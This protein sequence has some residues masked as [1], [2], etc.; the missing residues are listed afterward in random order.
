MSMCGSEERKIRLVFVRKPDL[1]VLGKVNE[2]G[3]DCS[4]ICKFYELC[5]QENV[6]GTLNSIPE[7]ISR[8]RGYYFGKRDEV[9]EHCDTH[10]VGIEVP[11]DLDRSLPGMIMKQVPSALYAVFVAVEGKGAPWG[12]AHE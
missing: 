4:R 1:N 12:E 10:M 3:T 7:L 5:S 2:I 6:W 9:P 8:T 11:L